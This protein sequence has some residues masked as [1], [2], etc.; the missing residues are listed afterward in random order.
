VDPLA[1]PA[2]AG[3]NAGA[4]HPLPQGGEGGNVDETRSFSVL[5]GLAA[6]L[7]DEKSLALM[8]QSFDRLLRCQPVD[9]HYFFRTL[10]L[11]FPDRSHIPE[12]NHLGNFSCVITHPP[13]MALNF[14]IETGLFPDLSDGALQP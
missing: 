7:P 4:V 5:L 8:I 12:A 6:D 11:R 10:K 3:E 9:G 13:R 2:P 1:R 14:H